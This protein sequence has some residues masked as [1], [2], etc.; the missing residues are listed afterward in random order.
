MMFT[1]A[2]RIKYWLL[3]ASLLENPQARPDRA[4]K[5]HIVEL[6]MF[7]CCCCDAAP[8]LQLISIIIKT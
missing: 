8:S 4:N 7:L 2:R 3:S 5:F 1:S 6:G